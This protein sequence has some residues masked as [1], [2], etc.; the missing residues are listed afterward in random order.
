MTSRPSVKPTFAGYLL[1][2]SIWSNAA[3]LG[4]RDDGS[5]VVNEPEPLVALRG[6]LKGIVVDDES[7]VP[8]FK[9]DS[10]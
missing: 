8:I 2:F 10:R 4:R 5:L 6:T 3:H 9:Y 7:I 1:S